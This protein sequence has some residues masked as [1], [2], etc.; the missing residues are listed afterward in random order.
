VH[1]I[2]TIISSLVSAKQEDGAAARIERIQNPIRSACVLHT[3]FSHVGVPRAFNP[4]GVRESQM[5]PLDFK[6]PN[7]CINRLLFGLDQLAPPSFKFV[8]VLNLP[9]VARYYSSKRLFH[10]MVSVQHSGIGVP[11]SL[12]PIPLFQV[13]TIWTVNRGWRQPKKQHQP[14]VKFACKPMPSH[15]WTGVRPGGKKKVA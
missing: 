9:H 3:E 13:E 7:R 12:I 14:G 4:A 11:W 8:D 1:L 6:K 2:P 5:R 10:Q 15:S